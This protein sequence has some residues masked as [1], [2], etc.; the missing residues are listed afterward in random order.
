MILWHVLGTEGILVRCV[1][2]PTY[3]V[4]WYV[5]SR[6]EIVKSRIGLSH[7]LKELEVDV[8]WKGH[9]NKRGCTNTKPEPTDAL[10]SFQ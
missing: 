6:V 7:T 5:L 1:G 10:W 4:V 8:R 2:A 3:M 9:A